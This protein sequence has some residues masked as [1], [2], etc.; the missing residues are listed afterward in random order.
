VRFFDI[1]VK[2]CDKQ[3]VDDI[4]KTGSIPGA[5]DERTCADGSRRSRS[6]RKSVRPP[7]T[8]AGDVVDGRCSRASAVHACNF[9]TDWNNPTAS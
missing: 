9:C 4:L 6:A 1:V 8:T 7:S 2:E 3:L 5:C